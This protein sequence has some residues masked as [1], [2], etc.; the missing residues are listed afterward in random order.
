MVRI[1][2]SV[3]AQRNGCLRKFEYDYATHTLIDITLGGDKK[4]SPNQFEDLKLDLKKQGF[5]FLL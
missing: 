4:I 1:T 3:C 2:E 5:K